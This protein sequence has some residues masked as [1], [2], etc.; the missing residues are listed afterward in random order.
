MITF[1]TIFGTTHDISVAQECARAVLVM[2]WGLLLLRLAGRRIFGRWAALDI[3]VAIIVGSSLSRALT[4]NAPLFGTL[5]ATSVLA[6]LHWALAKAAVHSR[7]VSRL[8]E[9]KAVELG[10][11]GT[12]HKAT[13]RRHNVTHADVAESL[14]QASLEEADGM[15][16]VF[17]EPSGRIVVWRRPEAE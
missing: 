14:H 17:L 3:V 12:M 15:R 8:L 9:G 4:G 13:I 11:D 2:L 7:A 1:D 6:L 16:R 10:R 5:L